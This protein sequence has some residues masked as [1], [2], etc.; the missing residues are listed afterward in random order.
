MARALMSPLLVLTA[1]VFVQSAT[2]QGTSPKP[3]PRAK[4]TTPAAIAFPNIVLLIVDD[5]GWQDL[6]VPLY[7][8]TTDA[9]RKYLTPAIARLA[10]EGVTFTDAYAAS[11]VGSP[12]RVTLLTGRSPAVTRVTNMTSVRGREE[13]TVISGILPPAWNVNGLSAAASPRAY[14]GPLLPKLLRNAGY[15]TIHIGRADWSAPGSPN[16]DAKALGFDESDSGAHRADSM[17]TSAVRAMDATVALKKPFF[18]QLAF[19]AIASSSATDTGLVREAL[20]R[21]LDADD[22]H[23]ASRIALVD[24]AI[25]SIMTWLDAKSLSAQT[26]VILTSDNGG[27][28]SSARP[29]LRGIQNAPLKSGMGSAYEGGLRVPMIVRWPNVARAGWRSQSPVI[30][31][32]LFPSLLHAAHIAL[33]STLTRDAIGRDLTSTLDTSQP[34]SL[35][36]VLLWHFPH[37]GDVTGAGMEP[38][39]AVRVGKWKLIYFYS[40]SRYELYDLSTDLGEQHELS[41]RQPEIASRLSEALRAAL[42]SANAQMPIDAAYGKPFGL[43]GRILV[44]TPPL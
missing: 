6:S 15:R 44:P 28:A 39:S 5:L 14:T 17:A 27:D 19:D 7:R 18:V 13:R 2:A 43:P 21:G 29:G 9:N 31:D 34:V 30:T 38:F 26:I 23:Y 10:A 24:R 8:D 25:Q 22:A 36:R 35:E 41:L 16:S 20:D 37:V 3:A 1:T 32:D 4:S 42:T 33:T 40:G 11:P 12:T